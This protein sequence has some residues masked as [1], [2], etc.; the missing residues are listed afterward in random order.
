[1][2]LVVTDIDRVEHS[3]CEGYEQYGVATVHE[4]LGRKGLMASYM[5]P[6]YRP[7][8]IAGTAVTC[9]VAP[10]DNWMIHVAAEQCQ[11]G[12]VLVV[13]PTSPCEDGYFG[14]LLATSLKSR[15]V[16]GLIIDAGVRDIATL[17]EMGFPV[18]SKAVYA[19]GTV[20]ETIANVNIPV[21]CA[22]AL[23]NP[24]DL[25]VA[26]DDGVVVV[27]RLEAQQ[28]LEKSKAR[29]E[30]EEAKRKRFE[31]GELGLDVYDM[32]ERLAK[33]GLKYVKQSEL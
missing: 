3:I 13:T 18:W 7:A 6:I 4:A 5:R 12:D 32:R 20:K 11:A 14:D 31:A 30:F 16:R 15:G 8:H 26:D 21:V 27:P 19:R 24:G 17:A 2:A 25:I 28:T 22:G 29:E 1:M 23:V 10:G 9:E 33:K